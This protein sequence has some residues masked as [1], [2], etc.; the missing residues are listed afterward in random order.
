MYALINQTVPGMA[1]AGPEETGSDPY[2]EYWDPHTGHGHGTG[3]FSW[4]AAL[5]LDTFCPKHLF[6]PIAGTQTT[7][8]SADKGDGSEIDG[9]DGGGPSLTLPVI[10]VVGAI[11]AWGSFTVPMK[12]EAVKAAQLDAMVFQ[13]Y[14][15]LGIVLSSCILLAIPGVQWQWTW[16]AVLSAVLWVPGSLCSVLAVNHL[17][18]AVAQGVWSGTS[19]CHAISRARART[20]GLPLP[21]LRWHLA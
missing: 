12:A 3:G 11:L 18:I 15:C 20:Q 8:E 7:E 10:G 17:G 13:G 4:T 5:F 19:V 1:V 2:R 9:G 21:Q 16:W 14:M 6:A